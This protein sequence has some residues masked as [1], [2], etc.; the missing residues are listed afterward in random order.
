MKKAILRFFLLISFSFFTLYMKAQNLVP[1]PSF[2]DT[3]NCPTDHSQ[4]NSTSN[5]FQPSNGTPDIYNSCSNDID[6]SAPLNFLGY[7]NARSGNAYSGIYVS[8]SNIG[9]G[10]NYR[11]Y[12]EVELLSALQLGETYY[13]SFFVSLADSMQTTS[14]QIGAFFSADSL[15]S[16]SWFNFSVVPQV[17]NMIGDYISDKQSWVLVSG[18]YVALGGERFITIG[19]FRDS[20]ST[21]LFYAGPGGTSFLHENGMVYF[22]IDDVCVSKSEEACINSLGLNSFGKAKRNIVCILDL[23]GR[24]VS[25]KPNTIQ[26]YIFD[27]GTTEKVFKVE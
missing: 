25:Y 14:D 26:I 20:S 6:A 4:I 21:S 3:L 2:E 7:Q 13:V 15:I 23:M 12:I 1:N 9:Y 5:W 19:N 17:E 11:E 8:S 24:K 22:Y 18:S 27:D 10:V 16:N